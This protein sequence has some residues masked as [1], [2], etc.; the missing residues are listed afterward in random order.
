MLAFPEGLLGLIRG[1]VLEGQLRTLKMGTVVARSPGSLVADPG[2]YWASVTMDGSSGTPQP[3][4]CF[5]SVLVDVGD[6]VGVGKFESDWIIIGNYTHRTLGDAG[7]NQ[8]YAGADTSTSGTFVDFP[9]SPNLIV[10]KRRDATG[11]RIDMEGSM[12]V[13]AQPTVVET[14][15]A[16]LSFD[17]TVAYD[18]TLTKRAFN[19]ASDHRSIAGGA[20]TAALAGGQTYSITARW[21]RVS[22][23]GTLT[24]DGNDS[25]NM[26]VREV[27]I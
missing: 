23:T 10:T 21:R 17:G 11:L 27:V 26:R 19:A 3:V 8:A 18:E 4:K 25:M 15:V 2:Q 6:R 14:A 16:I 5:E 24:V 7:F 12:Y 13:T 22:G 1:Q 9:E 20:T